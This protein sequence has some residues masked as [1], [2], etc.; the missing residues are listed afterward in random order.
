MGPLPFFPTYRLS[1]RARRAHLHVIGITGKG[2]SKLLEYCLFQDI[3]AG[4]GCVLID[5]HSDLVSDTL[6]L[7]LSQGVLAP[8]DAERVICFDPTRRDYALPFNVLATPGDPY[9]VAQGVVEAF[10]RTW[11]E[12]LREAP[13][14]SNVATAALITLIE[15]QCT[16]IDM[17]R[18]LV[19]QNWREQLLTR[20]S[21]PEVV[22]FFHERYDRWGREAP[23][24]RES[25]LNKVAAFT[26]N[27]DL[28]CVLGQR[29]N[30]LNFRSLM[31]QGQVLL[32]DLGRCD[33]ETRRLLGSLIVTSLEQAAVSR[34]DL[35]LEERRP[36]Y[37][38]IDEFQD[39]AANP[40]SAKS[41]AQILS[42]CRKFGLHLTLAHQNLSQLS[43]RMLGALGNIQTRIIFG[44][45][46]RDAEW[47]AREVGR[48]NTT[49]IKRESQTDT[50]HPVYAPL[51]DQW[52]EWTMRLKEQPTR[53]ALLADEWGV[54]SLWTMPIPRYTASL[55][56]VEH[57]WT[58]S[59]RVHGSAC[60]E[61]PKEVAPP[62][63]TSAPSP[64]AIVPIP[65]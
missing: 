28:R 38:Y 13:H 52:E 30:H 23:V 54:S 6:R 26:F 11:P 2:K 31:D 40:G 14:F 49:A 59:G 37:A 47:F 9:R 64:A 39:F 4:R 46:R 12:S 32:V 21:N 22:S 19:D 61:T 10:R 53:R 36:C 1:E 8:E 60:Q 25:T 17:H 41:L 58:A 7:C 57:F 48:V 65:L 63:A 5:P 29:A 42:E 16:L 27:P 44:V 3:A 55:A 51:P 56:D 20:V 33:G 35:P 34:H 43:E 50:Q 15:N 45:S 62:Q 18:L 24:L